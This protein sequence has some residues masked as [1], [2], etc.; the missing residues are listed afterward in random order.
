MEP[1]KTLY[2]VG[3]CPVCPGFGQ[4]IIFISKASASAVFYCPACGT[5]WDSPPDPP[6]HLNKVL[7]LDQIAPTGVRLPS[8]E[9]VDRILSQEVQTIDYDQWSD[10]LEVVLKGK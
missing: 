7:A 3:D 4:I 1:K 6:D 8:K 9:E 10:E 2:S 5:A